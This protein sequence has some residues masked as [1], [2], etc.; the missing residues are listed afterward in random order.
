MFECSKYGRNEEKE[1]NRKNIMIYI[2]LY[3]TSVIFN[4]FIDLFKNPNDYLSSIV[5][6]SLFFLS[7]FFGFLNFTLNQYQ[8]SK[9]I[10][11]LLMKVVSSLYL[12]LIIGLSNSSLYSDGISIVN[13]VIDLIYLVFL[14]F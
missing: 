5:K 1:Y 3:L 9:Y 2:L 6:L 4:I 10:P 8:T 13:I 7:T 12:V 14:H 11:F